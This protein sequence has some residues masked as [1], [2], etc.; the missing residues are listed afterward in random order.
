M[1]TW[2]FLLVHNPRMDNVLPIQSQ[3]GPFQTEFRSGELGERNS[4]V[5]SSLRCYGLSHWMSVL[6]RVGGFA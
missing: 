4:A 3:M 1:L 6:S 5:Q 2:E